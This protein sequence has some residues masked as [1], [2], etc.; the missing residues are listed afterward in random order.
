MEIENP[1]L[2]DSVCDSNRSWGLK[3]L[4]HASPAN[5]Y[6]VIRMHNSTSSCMKISPGGA[7]MHTRVCT[8]PVRRGNV[9][10]T[11]S[12]RKKLHLSLAAWA[13]GRTFL[14]AALA[15]GCTNFLKACYHDM[16][17]L[18]LLDKTRQLTVGISL[19]GRDQKISYRNWIMLKQD[20]KT[21]RR[22]WTML[23]GSFLGHIKV[24]II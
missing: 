10:T 23:G 15:A 9:L 13:E 11:I 24:N 1:T 8:W 18:L 19:L 12:R 16:D 20:Q 22:N 2:L 21:S 17:W 4:L 14:S 7:H 5:T 3:P 6:S